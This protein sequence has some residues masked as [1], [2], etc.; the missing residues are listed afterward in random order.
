[1]RSFTTEHV[2][3]TSGQNSRCFY[4]TGFQ[5]KT[6]ID[7][8]LHNLFDTFNYIDHYILVQLLHVSLEVHTVLSLK[9]SFF[10]TT[11]SN[12]NRK[13]V[14]EGVFHFWFCAVGSGYLPFYNQCCEY[15]NVS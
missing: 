2:K 4:Q 7:C 10:Y 14:T 13:P 6:K 9:T 12:V 8:C 15:W 5:K 3:D 1:M 11:E